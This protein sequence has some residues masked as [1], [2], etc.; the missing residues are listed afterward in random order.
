MDKRK[1]AGHMSCIKKPLHHRHCLSRSV[2][3]GMGLKQARDCLERPNT[4]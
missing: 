2:A 3:T 1:P 4:G